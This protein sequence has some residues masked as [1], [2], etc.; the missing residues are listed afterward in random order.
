[1]AISVKTFLNPLNCDEP[2]YEVPVLYHA[3]QATGA[4]Q[5]CA[6]NGTSTS[7]YGDYVS[8]SNIYSS[9]GTTNAA[10]TDIC[11]NGM[12]VVFLVDYTSSMTGAI[13]G[14]QSGINSIVT[15]IDSESS[16]NYR[17][18]LVTF[19][20][21]G[22]S[23]PAYGPSDY[24][25]NLPTDQVLNIS[26]P[27]GS[28]NL[29]ITCLEKMSSVGNQTS[30][31][32][33][34]NALAAGNSATGMQIGSAIEC[35][36]EAANR[37][38]MDSFAG[39]WRSG[40][41]KLIILIT[42]DDAEANQAFFTNT[43]IPNCSNFDVQ[44]FINT[45]SAS[46]SKYLSLAQNTVPAGA[47]YTSLNYG[48]NNWVNSM[49]SGITQLCQE[50]TTYTCDPAPVGWYADS[51]LGAG[52]TV[53]YWDGTNWTTTHTCQYTVTVDLVDNITNGSVDNI[54]GTHPN[55]L[56]ADTFTFTGE[57][58]D[59]FTA[60]IGNS[61]DSGYTNLQ[62]NVSNVSDT[63]VV[64]SATVNNINDEVTIT[65]EI[66]G[67]DEA[68]S[69]QINGSATQIQRTLRVDVVNGTTDTTNAA[70]QTQTPSGYIVPTE[71][72]PAS[73]WTD[74]GSTYLANARRYEFTGIPGQ[75]A[76]VDVNFL[77]NPS[78]YG[79]NVSSITII[80][81]D[82]SGGGGSSYSD[83]LSAIS[84]MTLTTG[85]TNPQWAGTITYPNTD[86]WVK[87]FVYGQVN[88][89]SYR[90][91]LYVS[92]SITGAELQSGDN[93]HTFQG[94]TGSQFNFESLVQ[95]ST[96]YQNPVVSG[97]TT[98]ALFDN[99]NGGVNNSLSNLLVNY[100]TDGAIGTVTI[101][102]GG[103]NA[104]IE[105]SGSATQTVHTFVVTIVDSLSTTTWGQVTFTGV[106]GSTPA[107]Q[108]STAFTN[109]EYTYNVTGAS[110]DSAD[111]VASVASATAPS[112]TIGLGE[113][114]MP[115]GGGSATV[116]LTGSETQNQ[117]SY[118]LSIGIDN[119]VLGSFIV[120]SATL[121]G[122]ASSVHTGTF[123]FSPVADNTYSS[124]LP[125]SRSNT[126]HITA[127]TQTSASNYTTAYEVTMPSGGGSGTIEIQ[128]ASVTPT[129]YSYTVIFDDS[130][131]AGNTNLT[132]TPS[133]Q[134]LTGTAGS[135]PSF[136]IDLD[137]SPSYYV[138]SIDGTSNIT[139]HDGNGAAG[140]ANELS[141]TGY[142]TSTNVISG[143]VLMPSG[144][145]TGYV[146]PKGGVTNPS[147]TFLVSAQESI[148]NATI[149][150]TSQSFTGITG[151]TH[152]YT[153]DIVPSS[154]YT[155]N[156]TNALVSNSY[157]GA[158]TAAPTASE[159]M[160]VNLTMPVNGGAATAIAYGTS[161]QT[162]YTASMTFDESD[163]L[164]SNGAWDDGGVV[165]TGVAGSTHTIDNTYRIT[166]NNLVFHADGVTLGI[167]P[168]SS[169]F[170]SM[171]TQ[172]PGDYGTVSRTTGTFTMPIGGGNWDLTISGRTA[173]TT[174]TLPTFTCTT[175]NSLF[176][177]TSQVVGQSI[178][179]TWDGSLPPMFLGSYSFNPPT[180]QLGTNS[181]D[182]DFSVPPGYS[183]EG[184]DFTCSFTVVG[185]TTTTTIPTFNCNDVQL[186]ID[187]GLA[188]NVVTATVGSKVDYSVNS[189]SPSTYP[190][191]AGQHMYTVVINVPSSGYT[192]SGFGNTITCYFFGNTILPT[193]TCT[194]AGYNQP[195]ADVGTSTCKPGQCLATVS[196]GTI[197]A[198]T[199]TSYQSGT[200]TYTASITVPSGY[201]NAGQTIT[202]TD[203]ATGEDCTAAI[204]AAFSLGT[205][206][207][208]ADSRGTV[209]GLGQVSQSP[210]LNG[211]LNYIIPSSVGTG[212][213]LTFTITGSI[214][215]LY[216]DGPGGSAVQAYQSDSSGNANASGGYWTYAFNQVGPG[217]YTITVAKNGISGCNQI[218]TDVLVHSSSMPVW[219]CEQNTGGFGQLQVANGQEGDPIIINNPQGYTV[220]TYSP[221]TY[222]LGQAQMNVMVTFV[223]PD[224]YVPLNSGGNGSWNNYQVINGIHYITCQQ[225]V[226][227]TATTTTT[228][229]G[230]GGPREELGPG[231]EGIE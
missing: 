20:G 9:G 16:G 191:T 225:S 76:N 152:S 195:N 3:D 173:G 161:T 112:V 56:D 155:T 133:T 169:E 28:G 126:S 26:N 75:S 181:Y 146:R 129:Q 201:T 38:T 96:D 142:N 171:A 29:F 182:M 59:I 117:Y 68:E 44:V 217:N 41:L 83:G 144:G 40:V 120:N 25:Q 119:V 153:F 35:G 160:I 228:T 14:V 212:S 223:L 158:L 30:F 176:A 49:I 27:H 215:G 110:S 213:D 227:I 85:S 174:T 88:Q 89:P 33:N 183:N 72:T 42:D 200:N 226:N 207:S 55:Y 141:I 97:V 187:D 190:D 21:S 218:Y 47:L 43:L 204:Q 46:D 48:N 19:D 95:A 1:M 90:V 167:S 4:Q 199:P 98:V 17:L 100:T 222:T 211:T 214:P 80:S 77:P 118:E 184:D 70:G 136:T 58:G 170:S 51:P 106:T 177:N 78:D 127:A 6:G 64:T 102:E 131:M 10:N 23:S 148:S 39:Q 168:T 150:P 13:S 45:S 139:T 156:V 159:D 57:P 111:C 105:L 2:A 122:A 230:S 180:Y 99:S 124:T 53:Y 209:Y 224:G 205:W 121:T 178:Q 125:P 104:G 73:G 79:V 81:T 12:D 210:A 5:I 107:N 82:L 157:G 86:S 101:P 203:T 189:I 69:I 34:L 67:Q 36:A 220:T 15:Q 61:P 208:S 87:I 54:L 219:M 172:N 154:G 229:S 31:T 231:G 128:N 134:T 197:T 164:G 50:T 193:F 138:I 145:G 202:C 66:Q 179:F 151:S 130:N 116:T 198:V 94:Y 62:V 22:A 37:I 92:E 91:T 123:T 93:Q 216:T 8:L 135:T 175:F 32:T 71:E 115:S 63:N 165:F 11:A 60:T 186:T 143:Q 140:S 103:G 84:N 24:Y 147:F 65:V 162:V 221:T 192:N 166:N 109:S 113:S 194:D 185:T 149:T 196:A 206:T 52:A 18:G 188:G 108:T 137:P 114:G 132:A 7:I 74:V 163:Q